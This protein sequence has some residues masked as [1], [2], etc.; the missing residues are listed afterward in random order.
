MC[1]TDNYKEY[2][3]YKMQMRFIIYIHTKFHISSSSGSVVITVKLKAKYIIY[4]APN[5][6]FHAP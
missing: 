6:L 3:I 4:S 1:V 5:L 2:F